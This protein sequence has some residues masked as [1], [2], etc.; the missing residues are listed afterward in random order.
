MDGA[1]EAM[2][3]TPRSGRGLAMFS[4]FRSTILSSFAIVSISILAIAH[5]IAILIRRT[6]VCPN[7]FYSSKRL[8]KTLRVG[9]NRTSTA[10]VRTLHASLW[11]WRSLLA[12]ELGATI[13]YDDDGQILR[14]AKAATFDSTVYLSHRSLPWQW[15]PEAVGFKRYVRVRWSDDFVDGPPGTREQ[16]WERKARAYKTDPS[17]ADEAAI[18]RRTL[19]LETLSASPPIFRVSNL[20]PESVLTSLITHASPSFEPSTVGD[21]SLTDEQRKLDSKRESNSAWLHGFNDPRKTL[22]AARAVQR[23]VFD[24]LRFSPNAG[25]QLTSHIEPLLVVQ[26]KPGSFYEPHHDFFAGGGA[27]TEP[28]EAA[29]DPQQEGGSNRFA[30]L[31]IYLEEPSVVPAELGSSASGALEAASSSVEEKE[32][33]EAANGG[34]QTVFPFAAPSSDTTEDGASP[35]SLLEGVDFAEEV[36]T[37][38]FPELRQRGGLMVRP[39]R[40]DALLF[41][42]QTPDGRLDGR[43][44]HGACPVRVG[45][46]TVANAW[47]WNGPVIYR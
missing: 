20:L 18:S 9:D 41:Y 32:K 10:V 45:R 37:C 26:Y 46:K 40:G 34:G 15:A 35:S 47:L 16:K 38:D 13:V 29:F 28:A 19:T 22:P 24:L 6:D 31:L 39:K 42:S 17:E 11:P 44:R 5:L 33:V 36:K 2:A 43:T 4:S 7:D 30:T 23:A 1:A 21:P 25:Q 14:C 8:L 12:K 27:R 3:A